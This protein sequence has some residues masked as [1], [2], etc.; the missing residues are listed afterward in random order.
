[1]PVGQTDETVMGPLARLLTCSIEPRRAVCSRSVA[2]P[3]GP[4]IPAKDNRSV[5]Q[6]TSQ[7]PERCHG[8]SSLSGQVDREFRFG[9][10]P[11]LVLRHVGS[12]FAQEETGVRDVENAEVGD[13][14]LDDS[15][16]RQGQ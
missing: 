4:T 15:A 11:H 1:M 8:Q 16:T 7:T 10:H 3:G 9:P 13:D 6:V 14:P 12:E 5:R 2:P